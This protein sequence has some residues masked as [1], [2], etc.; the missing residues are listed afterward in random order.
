MTRNTPRSRRPA[1]KA[2]AR[3]PAVDA[4]TTG[5]E[6]VD[7]G[8]QRSLDLTRTM[9]GAS[10][11]ASQEWMRGLGEWQQAQ[12]LS[13]RNACDRIGQVAG[14]AEAAPDWPSLWAVQATL[15]S[16]QWTQAM[17]DCSSL[18]E[19]AMQIE[20]RLVERGRADATRLSQQW[21]GGPETEA[22]EAAGAR[23][24][25][26][27]ADAAEAGTPLAMLTQAQA[28]MSE[29][30]RLWTQALYHTALPD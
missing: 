21:L 24:S 3:R 9:L 19:R 16:T 11:G 26:V 10:L 5:L 23:P 17:Q 20:A 27:L 1:A 18:I 25:S 30:S 13:L 29:M 12:A 28:A 8:W 7:A 2:V 14:Q 4:S 6:P 15:A 22:P